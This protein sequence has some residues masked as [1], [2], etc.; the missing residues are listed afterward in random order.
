VEYLLIILGGLVIGFFA[1]ILGIGGGIL[2]VPM[3]NL[4]F[5]V[6]MHLAIGTSLLCVIATSSG[7]AVSYVQNRLTNIR[8]GMSL[9]LATTLG[10]IAGGLLAGIL[11]RQT[12]SIFFS[13]LLAYASLSMLSKRPEGETN[14]Y[15]SKDNPEEYKVS[16]FPLGTGTSLFA[17]IVSGLLGVGGGIIKVPVM[18]LYMGVPLKAAIATSNFMIGV[19]AS[20]SCFLYY[21]RGDVNLPI[22]ASSVIGIFIGAMIGS[23]YIHKIKVKYL[24]KVFVIILVYVSL[25]MFFNGIGF[26]FLIF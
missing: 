22:S 13:L 9:E 5:G 14:R 7:A 4:L 10:A 6:P 12:L 11:S 23:K 2:I 16:N 26:H 21:F 15:I 19:T 17:G 8:L 20:A 18:D 1:S 25:K 24:R 3:L